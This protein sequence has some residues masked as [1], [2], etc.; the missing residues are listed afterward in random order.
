LGQDKETADRGSKLVADLL[1]PSR[2]IPPLASDPEPGPR[3]LHGPKTLEKPEL[4]WPAFPAALPR[5]PLAQGKPLQPHLL[6]EA[7]PLSQERNEPRAPEKPKLPASKFAPPGLDVNQPVPLPVLAKPLPDR[8]PLG[9][10]TLEASVA[11]ALGEPL[12]LRTTPVPFL[13]LNLPDPF[14][15]SLAVRLRTPHEENPT[16]VPSTPRTPAK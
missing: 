9:D 4:P 15:N 8:A 3:R 12:P 11:A 1:Q 6:A 5:L 16:P 14:E 13:R 7:A 10:P 2:K